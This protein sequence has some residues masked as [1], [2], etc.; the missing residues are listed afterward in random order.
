MEATLRTRPHAGQ[1]HVHSVG[2]AGSLGQRHLPDL[3]G[4]EAELIISTWPGCPRFASRRV[5]QLTVARDRRGW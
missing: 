5:D 2:A 4:W 3:I 1:R